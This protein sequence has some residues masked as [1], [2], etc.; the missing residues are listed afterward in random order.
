MAESGG[1][2]DDSKEKAEQFKNEANEQ[3]KAEHYGQ[4]IELYTKVWNYET[5]VGSVLV[6]DFWTPPPSYQFCTWVWQEVS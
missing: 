3:F 1:V 2:S 4:A 6:Y 5:F